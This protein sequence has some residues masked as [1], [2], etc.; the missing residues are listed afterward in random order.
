[1]LLKRIHD[2]PFAGCGYAKSPQTG[3][4]SFIGDI[5]ED[6]AHATPEQLLGEDQL[7]ANVIEKE[8]ISISPQGYL[9]VADQNYDLDEFCIM[10][11]EY[12]KLKLALYN[13]VNCSTHFKDSLNA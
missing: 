4:L 8:G 11:Y 1:M 6:Y 5:I 9:N 10:N 12:G 3:S 7:I 13:Y 2:K